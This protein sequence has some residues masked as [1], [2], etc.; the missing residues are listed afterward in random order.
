VVFSWDFIISILFYN[1]KYFV[2]KYNGLSCVLGN[3]IDLYCALSIKSF[4]NN[5]G[6]H[7]ILF[8]TKFNFIYDFNYFFILNKPIEQLEF[9]KFFLFIACDLR[10]ESPLFNTRL[11]KNYNINKNSG[12]FFFSY[13]ISLNYST[14]PVKN[15][16][17][18]IL[19]FLLFM[20]GK[21]RFFC[22][23]FF[24]GFKAFAFVNFF[25]VYFFQ[26]PVIFLGNSL[27]YRG[28]LK[29][30]IFSFIF[31][32][33]KKFNWLSFNFVNSYLG[34]FSYSS[35]LYSKFLTLKGAYKGFLYLVSSELSGLSD[36]SIS[37][38]FVVYQ[39]FL[40]NFSSS[41]NL[42]LPVTAPYE[43]NCLF[44]NLE[45]RLKNLKQALNSGVGLNND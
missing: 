33:K 40:K 5:F 25:D 6:C 27:L 17:N 43:A 35:I 26:K 37:N 19:K 7:N 21:Q 34:F 44:I 16:G 45:G 8:N 24:K 12:L 38:V 4:F 18:S 11:K 30:F 1:I 9:I 10:L 29:S 42:I 31:F 2:L 20:E 15:L 13:G 36:L 41:I 28:D 3:F 32:F 14:Y 22:D 39:G 23:F